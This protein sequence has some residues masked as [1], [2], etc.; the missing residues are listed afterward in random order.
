MSNYIDTTLNLLLIFVVGSAVA[1]GIYMFSASRTE[2]GWRKITGVIFNG[3]T[4]A[5][6]AGLIVS[7]FFNEKRQDSLFLAGMAVVVYHIGP[8]AIKRLVI[9]VV[10]SRMPK[11]VKS[12][13]DKL[14][15]S[16]DL[17]KLFDT[18]EYSREEIAAAIADFRKRLDEGKKK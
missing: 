2:S 15:N 1:F 16:V 8:D 18:G 14:E 11:K 3:G 6:I 12:E 17:K 7:L 5:L 9:A 13:F 4:T 10:M